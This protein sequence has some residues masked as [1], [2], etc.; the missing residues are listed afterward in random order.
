MNEKIEYG[1]WFWSHKLAGILAMLAE[2]SK[3]KLDEIEI[4]II[5]NDLKGTN[6]ELNQ[7][8]NYPLYGKYFKM[9]LQF[10]YDAEEK[11]D[12]IHI[13]IKTNSILKEKL[14]ALN[15]FQCMFT[16]LEKEN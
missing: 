1:F 14:E 13:K 5:Q 12:M 7:W 2:L 10:A 6:D 4:G 16:K 8:T 3:Y 15:L 11:L 9:D